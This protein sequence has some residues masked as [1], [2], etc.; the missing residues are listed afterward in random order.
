[1]AAHFVMTYNRGIVLFGK[2][3]KEA[4][5]PIDNRYYIASIKSDVDGALEE[6][7][8]NPVYYV[9]NLSRVLLFLRE[10]VISS[11]KEAGDWALG[12][13][14]NHYENIIAQCLRRYEN[15]SASLY[16]D[17]KM[18]RNYSEYMLKEI[19]KLI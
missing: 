18:F 9:L 11:K 19:E 15:E 10:S 14:P 6:I 4:F 16:L 13:L 5:K 8:E 3:I 2:P 12:E 7:T 1:M 17:E